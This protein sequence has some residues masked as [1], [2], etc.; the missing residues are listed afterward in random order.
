MRLC[1]YLES[2][3]GMKS[4]EEE[5]N[6]LHSR[7]C[8]ALADPKCIL[9]LYAL[10]EGPRNV[11]ELC[12]SLGLP[13]PTTSRQLRMLRERGLVRTQR[14]A[15]M[16]I[17]TLADRRVIDALDLL[18][19]VLADQLTSQ[20]RIAETVSQQLEDYEGNPKEPFK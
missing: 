2:D 17:Y 11:S 1:T 9:L 10:D 15:N 4:I 8:A 12:Q 7:L 16:V 5:I 18:R 19:A 3:G 13:Q 20:A 14:E 6:L